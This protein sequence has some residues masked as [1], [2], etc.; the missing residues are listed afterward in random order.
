MVKII[1]PMKKKRDLNTELCQAIRAGEPDKVRQL[2][3]EGADINAIGNTVVKATPLWLAVDSAGHEVSDNWVN[4]RD[5]LS[6][7]APNIPKRDY[8]IKR[9]KQFLIIEILI[10]AG[11]DL[12][13]PCHG[14]V[15]LRGAVYWQDSES[16]DLLLRNGANPNA[17]N[18]SILSKLAKKEGRKTLLGYYDT[19]VASN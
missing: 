16:I 4:F 1:Q 12:E 9:Q 3:G 2:L 19:R 11:A 6:D 7:L 10:E 13:K 18:F 17:E 8:S 14:T 5:M 15:P